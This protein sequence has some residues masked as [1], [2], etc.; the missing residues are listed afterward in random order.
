MC[1]FGS[2]L[3]HA[4][5]VRPSETT[6][7]QT[8]TS[9]ASSQHPIPV[10]SCIFLQNIDRYLT[11]YLLLYAYTVP[12]PSRGEDQCSLNIHVHPEPQKATLFGKEG[13]CRCNGRISRGDPPGFKVSNA[14]CLERERR[15]RFGD[16]KR[17]SPRRERGGARSS[18]AA[19]Q[20]TAGAPKAGRG[21][22]ALSARAFRGDMALVTPQFW[23]FSS[24]T[25]R[26]YTCVAVSH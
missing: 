21:E 16:T 9:G 8:A 6:L 18:A 5:S 19:S 17:K 15:G 23:I 1:S 7:V 10:L 20:E 4:L 3:R 24:G 26:E 12:L 14:W 13:L 22:G 2:W 25:G 11:R